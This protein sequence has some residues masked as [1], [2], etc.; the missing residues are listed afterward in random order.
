MGENVG[1]SVGLREVLWV[2][3]IRAGR[4]GKIVEI[5]RSGDCS[6]VSAFTWN[7]IADALERHS[8]KRRG[9]RKKVSRDADIREAFTAGRAAGIPYKQVVSSIAEHF[10]LSIK[11]VE[12]ILDKSDP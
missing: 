8:K 9:A 11:G 3:D 7:A 6:C 4:Y 1:Y 2:A 10:H 12:S 5:L